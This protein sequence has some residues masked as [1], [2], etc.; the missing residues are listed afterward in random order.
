MSFK[1]IGHVDE[2]GSIDLREF[3]Y[4]EKI[5]LLSKVVGGNKC[6]FSVGSY[7]RG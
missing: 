2:N 1:D 6:A 5:T 3:F 4:G 7:E